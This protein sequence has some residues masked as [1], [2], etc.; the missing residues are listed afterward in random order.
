MSGSAVTNRTNP[1]AAIKCACKA[2]ECI[3]QPGQGVE[4]DGKLYCSRACAYDCTET[5]CV[6]VHDRCDGH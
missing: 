1:P 5:T 4:R 2:C 3:V 6:C